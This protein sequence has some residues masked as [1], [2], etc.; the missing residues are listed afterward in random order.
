MNMK[1]NKGY[2]SFIIKKW[3]TKNSFKYTVQAIGALGKI[4]NNIKKRRK[5]LK[6][7]KVQRN[8]L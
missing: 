7:M 6:I 1:Q 2:M 8:L 5:E 3:F 4:N